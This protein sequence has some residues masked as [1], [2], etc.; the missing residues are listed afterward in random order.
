LP[1]AAAI[2]KLPPDQQAQAI[3][4]PLPR[5][6]SVI[7]P[8]KTSH[9]DA[10]DNAPKG[11]NTLPE[12][13]NPDDFGPSEEEMAEALASEKADRELV[14]K[15]LASD[16][17]LAELAAEVKRL[18]LMVEQLTRRN[19]S[20]LDE[21]ADAQRWMKKYEARNRHLLKEMDALKKGSTE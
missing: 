12:G 5:T 17:V 14:A 8:P 21:K 13:I 15:M 7:P 11:D 4:K 1:K 20:L 10:W 2:A 16:D 18:T 6:I 19:N 9:P 3:S